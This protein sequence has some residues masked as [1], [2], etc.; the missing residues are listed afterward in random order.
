MLAVALLAMGLLAA[1]GGDSRSASAELTVMVPRALSGADV[2][3]VQ[4]EVSGPGITPPLTAE[5]APRGGSWTGLITGIPAGAGRLFRASAYDAASKL[6]YVGEAGPLPIEPGKTASIAILLQ[7]AEPQVPFENEAPR[8]DSVAVSANP[9]EPGASVT[10]TATAHDANPGDTLRY[11]WSATAGTF[12]A[13]G[14]AVTTWT[15]PSTEGAQRIQLEV[16]DSKGASATLSVDIGVL[17]PGSTGSATVSASFNT[18]PAITAMNGAPSVLV[19]GGGSRLTATVTDADGDVPGFSWTSDCSGRFD[20]PALASPTFFVVALPATGR[21]AFT[22]R[23]TDGRGG[24]HLGTLTLHAGS[25]AGS[26]VTGERHLL[27]VQGERT[28][29]PVP[30]DLSSVT[31]GAWVPT[32]DGLGYAWRAG[33]GQTNGT[34]SVPDVAP[35]S[36]YLLRFGR[37]YLWTDKRSV[38]LSR[39]A[40]GRPGVE[41]EPEGTQLQLQLAGL[42]PWTA[43]DDLQ[44]HSPTAGLD[45]VSTA[46]CAIPADFPLPAEG[47]TSIWGNTSYNDYLDACANRPVRFNPPSDILYVTQLAGRTDPVTGIDYQ[48]LRRG[49]RNGGPERVGPDSLLLR[50]S[51]GVLPTFPQSLTVRASE[52]EALALSGH[53]SASVSYSTLDIGTLQGYSL[54]G[55]YASWPDLGLAYDYTPGDGDFSPAFVLGELFP[56]DWSLF[57]NFQLSASVS[58]AI[59]LPGGGTSKPR[60]FSAVMI[61]REPLVRGSSPVLVPKMGPA[62]ALRINGLEATGKLSG[63]GTTPLLHWTVPA[64]GAPTYYQLRLYRLFS[65]ADGTTS[66]QS[67]AAFYTPQTQL[68]LPPG[69]LTAGESYYVQVVSS[70]RP[71][72]D[73]SN[74]YKDS[75]VSH[76]ASA[77]T[78]VFKP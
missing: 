34:F 11:N 31:I 49:L 20:D 22:L 2:S 44:L 56:R 48:E 65:L 47:G 19:L 70:L 61:A 6:L 15:A 60:S 50:G 43:L 30:D 8:I 51:L 3:R 74:P 76:S 39:A 46:G 17:L 54:F 24:Q 42:S 23:V 36:S 25:A 66:R 40:V 32:P 62:R 63:V 12:S 13:P 9:V 58:Y 53:P 26:A 35:G 5:L 72:A 68:R 4:V 45:W 55:T 69:L 38:E 77:L 7:Q 64:L 21:C 59:D 29:I 28:V 57:S 52:F 73:P 33:S 78:G 16:V 37:D 71:G 27:Y 18:W 41:L 10:L 1:C 67:V 14:S 75:P